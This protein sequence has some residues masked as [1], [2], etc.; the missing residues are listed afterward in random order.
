MEP[1]KIKMTKEW[2]E[3]YWRCPCG[4]VIRN[5][6]RVHHRKS[7][8]HKKLME[9]KDAYNE[10]EQVVKDILIKQLKKIV[11]ELTNDRVLVETHRNLSIRDKSEQCKVVVDSKESES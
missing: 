6:S 4:T 11:D 9:Q 3:T 1:L 8:R 2:C 10:V 5:A 7:A